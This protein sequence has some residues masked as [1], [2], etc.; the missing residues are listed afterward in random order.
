MMICDKA[1]QI[2]REAASC[3]HSAAKELVEIFA[4]IT[5]LGAVYFNKFSCILC[6]QYF[7]S[8]RQD[9]LAVPESPIMSGI[10]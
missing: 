8:A 10:S 9:S 5:N 1:M 2:Y 7:G 6:V 3:D 4:N